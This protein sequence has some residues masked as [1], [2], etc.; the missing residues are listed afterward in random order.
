MLKSVRIYITYVHDQ[1]SLIILVASLPRMVTHPT[2]VEAT[3][4]EKIVIM[5]VFVEG[6]HLNY[7][8]KKHRDP[9][10]T[11]GHDLL[12]GDIYSGTTTCELQIRTIS[13]KEEGWY[14]CQVRNARGTVSSNKAQLSERT[15]TINYDYISFTY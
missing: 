15:N 5:S 4:G 14:S 7:Q 1:L 2:D 10:Q 12:D 13:T 6:A 11:L 8:W 3:N 9:S